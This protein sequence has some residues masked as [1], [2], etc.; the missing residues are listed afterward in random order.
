MT[1]RQLVVAENKEVP[2]MTHMLL[3]ICTSQS[4]FATMVILTSLCVC[5]CVCAR[6]SSCATKERKCSLGGGMYGKSGRRMKWMDGKNKCREWGQ[7]VF[8]WATKVV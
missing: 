3:G 2:M 4:L 6:E 7:V 1:K 8:R 5:V